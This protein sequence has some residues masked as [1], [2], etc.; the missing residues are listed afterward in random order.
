[1]TAIGDA[2]F[3]VLELVIVASAFSSGVAVVD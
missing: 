1:M 3:V 2:I